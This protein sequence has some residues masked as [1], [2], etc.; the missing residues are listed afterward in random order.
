MPLLLAPVLPLF[1]Q[2]GTVSPGAA[3]STQGAPLE[4]HRRGKPA[5]TATAPAPPPSHLLP[6]RLSQC[7]AAAR[8]DP[9]NALDSAGAWLDSVKGAERAEPGQCLGLALTR[10]E[11][12]DQAVDAFRGARDALPGGST[13]SFSE[14]AERARLGA[15]IANAL[16]ADS[17][18][19]KAQQALTELDIAHGDALGASDARLAGEISIDRARALVALKREGDAAAALAEARANVPDNAQ[20][21]LLSATLAR[22][23]GQ[24]AEAQ[25][26]IERAAELAPTD[27]E[28]GLEAGVIAVLGGHDAAARQSWESVIKAA[29]DSDAAKT[30][31]SYLDQL[32]PAAPSPAR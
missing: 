23:Q 26:Q 12:W 20:A 31:R 14:R 10:L 25:Q 30:A 8:T 3:P 6:S 5:A 19:A 27:P 2:L 7:L 21:W 4:I 28:T 11:R 16:L 32:A 22:R 1:L 15:M 29:P 17:P 9:V 18:A 24:L 13:A